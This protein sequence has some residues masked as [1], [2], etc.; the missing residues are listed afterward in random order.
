MG[1][2]LW[3]LSVCV[4]P[5]LGCG[6]GELMAGCKTGMAVGVMVC[7]SS[8]SKREDTGLRRGNELQVGKSHLEEVKP[9]WVLKDD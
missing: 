9:G 3:A 6:H 5:V 7:G 1:T 4:S 8:R 2:G